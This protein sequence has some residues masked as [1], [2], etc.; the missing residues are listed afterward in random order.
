MP[1]QLAQ[2]EQRRISTPCA[3]ARSAPAATVCCATRPDW[4]RRTWPPWWRCPAHRAQEHGPTQ[5]AHRA[6]HLGRRVHRNRVHATPRRRSNR[7]RWA[8]VQ[9]AACWKVQNI[10]SRRGRREAGLAWGLEG[11]FDR[12][13][14]RRR[15]RLVRV[16]Q[17]HPVVAGQGRSPPVSAASIPGRDVPR[18]AP[19]RAAMSAVASHEPESST[20]ISSAQATLVRQPQ[21]GGVVQRGH[22]H[23][24]RLAHQAASASG[25]SAWRAAQWAA[26]SHQNN[27]P[28][29]AE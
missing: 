29:Q 1:R 4:N 27:S 25:R 7:R 20:T 23:R 19:W 17:E 24:Q 2:E 28:H 16:E 8:L 11:C 12:R 13:A 10:C 22:H 15:Q 26:S 6:V 5:G 3:C 18:S 21:R 9:E 14:R